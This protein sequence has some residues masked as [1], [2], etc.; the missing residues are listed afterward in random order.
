MPPPA[1]D[2]IVCASSVT[3]TRP[4]ATVIA[5]GLPPTGIVATTLLVS[6]SMRVTVPSPL[7]ATQT[8]PAPTATPLGERPTGIVSVTEREPGSIRVTLLSSES[9]THTPPSPTAIP[10]GPL[11]TAIGVMQPGRVDARDVVG[12]IVGDPDGAVADVDGGRARVRI[13]PLNRP[14]CRRVKARKQPGG[15]GDPDRVAARGDRGRPARVDVPDPH[16]ASE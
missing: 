4:S 10:V 8:E 9:A 7:L 14:R 1:A 15:R 13:D 3:H 5:C 6:G 11:P 2:L 12:L 16:R